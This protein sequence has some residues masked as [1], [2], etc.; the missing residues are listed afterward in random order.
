MVNLLTRRPNCNF[1][2]SQELWVQFRQLN[3]T[4]EVRAGSKSFKSTTLK[5]GVN[6]PFFDRSSTQYFKQIKDG[7]CL[8]TS[9]IYE[10]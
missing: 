6:K 2:I 1:R 8:L 10:P 7:Q 4:E 5:E 3:I 9:I